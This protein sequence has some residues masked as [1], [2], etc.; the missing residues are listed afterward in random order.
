MAEKN[1]PPKALEFIF[2]PEIKTVLA[3]I[4]AHGPI[5]REL[6]ANE[7]KINASKLSNLL[8]SLEMNGEI[9][10]LAGNRYAIR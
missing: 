2:S 3:H 6:I 9:Q 1:S 4:E 7:L 10:L 5:H 8:L